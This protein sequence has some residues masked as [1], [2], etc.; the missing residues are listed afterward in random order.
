MIQKTKTVELRILTAENGMVLTDGNSFS[1]VGGEVYL[2][3]NEDATNWY[4]VT[5]AKA[6]EMKLELE[7][8]IR[9]QLEQE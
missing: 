5:E 1:S 2:G 9:E 4:E 7:R 3:K 8:K 6:E